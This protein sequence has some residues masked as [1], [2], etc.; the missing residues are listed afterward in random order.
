MRRM[1]DQS[2]RLEKRRIAA[3][4][5]TTVM[6]PNTSNSLPSSGRDA[7]RNIIPR[8]IR[9]KCVFGNTSPMYCAKTGMPSKGNMN[10]DRRIDGS[11]TSATRRAESKFISTPIVDA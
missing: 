2:R 9:I 11:S 1:P 5:A 8:V 7:S 3:V 10:P 4:M 6:A